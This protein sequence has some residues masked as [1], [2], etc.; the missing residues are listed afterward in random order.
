[1]SSKGN[2]VAFIFVPDMISRLKNL[3]KNFDGADVIA[4]IIDKSKTSAILVLDDIAGAA[5]TP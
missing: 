5:V 1:M 2:T 4:D 3:I